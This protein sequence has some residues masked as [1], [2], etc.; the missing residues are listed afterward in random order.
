MHG[1]VWEISPIGSCIWILGPHVVVLFRKVIM[2]PLGSVASVEEVWCWGRAF[3]VYS[4][5]L[6]LFF[7][8]LPMCGWKHDQTASCSNHLLPCPPNH[9]GIPLWNANSKRNSFFYNFLLVMVFLIPLT[10]R[11]HIFKKVNIFYLYKRKWCFGKVVLRG[12]GQSAWTSLILHIVYLVFQSAHL[13]CRKKTWQSHNFRQ[14]TL[15]MNV[16][17]TDRYFK[18]EKVF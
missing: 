4:F 11:L 2:E 8:L 18:V 5:I 14:V 16:V 9:N 7:A 10:E 12:A 17:H 6:S 1:V 3:R 13:L 15:Q